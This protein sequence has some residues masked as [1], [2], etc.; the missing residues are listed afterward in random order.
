MERKNEPLHLK[1]QLRKVKIN[2]YVMA[3]YSVMC[4]N[5]QYQAK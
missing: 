2:G 5:R 4:F 1:K 3:V